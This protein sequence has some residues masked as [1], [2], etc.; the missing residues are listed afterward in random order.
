MRLRLTISIIEPNR[1]K[2][3][4]INRLVPEQRVPRGNRG[5]RNWWSPEV[6]T[7]IGVP[8]K[9]WVHFSDEFGQLIIYTDSGATELFRVD[10]VHA[11]FV[12]WMLLSTDE[13]LMVSVKKE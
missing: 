12:G 1:N 2:L 8:L 10:G 13:R 4:L 3:E 9:A 6:N 5:L 7:P 11:P